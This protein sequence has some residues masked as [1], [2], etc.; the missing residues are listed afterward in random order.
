ML[1][2]CKLSFYDLSLGTRF[3]SEFWVERTIKKVFHEI[4]ERC[5]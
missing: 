2:R 1:D 4:P 3:Y 5:S